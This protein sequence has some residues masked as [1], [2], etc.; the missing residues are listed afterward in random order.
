M[1]KKDLNGVRTAQDLERKYNFKSL[2]EMGKAVEQNAEGLAKIDKETKDFVKEVLKDLDTLNKSIDG[3]VDVYF[4]PGVPTLESP[5][6]NSWNDEEKEEHIGDLYYDKETGIPYIF[7]KEEGQYL[8]IDVRDDGV[9][10]A[11]ALANAAQDTA[12]NKRRVFIEQ[13]IPPY[14]NG[15]IWYKEGKL[16]ICQVSKPVDEEYEENDFIELE[17]TDDTYATKVNDELTIVKGTVT[18]IKESQ[19]N[20]TEEFNTTISRVN[21]MD[22]SIQ[23]EISERKAIIRRGV[24]ENGNPVIELGASDNPVKALYKNDGMYIVTND[25]TTSY[26]K[27]GKAYNYDMEATNS[28]QIGKFIFKPRKNGNLSLVRVVSGGWLNGVK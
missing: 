2:F 8:W 27:D 24:D 14:D 16:L 18:I 28:L 26:Y 5:P 17:Y 9:V 15:D 7:Q 25:Q 23:E 6:T 13:P 21:K 19:D 3:K 12:D 20:I 1:D 4:Y 11:L 10:D 22:D